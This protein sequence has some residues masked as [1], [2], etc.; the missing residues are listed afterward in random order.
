M[1][2]NL[3]DCS[4]KHLPYGEIDKEL[5]YTSNSSPAIKKLNDLGYV[6]NE[7][8]FESIKNLFSKDYKKFLFPYENNLGIYI[9]AEHSPK[10]L[11]KKFVNLT[12]FAN[13]EA[14]LN[15]EFAIVMASSMGHYHPQNLNVQEVYEFK[16]Y[17]AM[18]INKDEKTDFIFLKP[19][20]KVAVP[21]NC[22]MT[23]YNLDNK[24]LKTLDFANPEKNLSNKNL[25]KQ[26]GPMFC[27]Y[28]SP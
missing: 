23:I 5:K 28:Y 6:L 22:N 1:K 10:D 3:N 11:M 7:R 25:Q 27:I 8:T 20:E 19:N 17:G 16:G 9:G 13:L 4:I 26:K 18:L 14:A 24:P 12:F 21:G 2:L 15:K